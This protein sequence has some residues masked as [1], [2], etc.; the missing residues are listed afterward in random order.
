M[1]MV[2]RIF[3]ALLAL[4]GGR[5]IAQIDP[6]N[7]CL[8]GEWP[9]G[10]SD[11][12]A[13]DSARGLAFFRSGQRIIVA[14]VATPTSIEAISKTLEPADLAQD[15]FYD[16]STQRLYVAAGLAGLEI[17][18]LANPESPQ[19]LSDIQLDFF[20][21]DAPIHG[22]TVVGDWAYVAT[23]FRGVSWIDV[24]DPENPVAGLWISPCP[25]M[26]G[27]GCDQSPS[28]VF[29]GDDG[30]LYSTGR[31]NARLIIQPDGSLSELYVIGAGGVDIHVADGLA[32]VVHESLGLDIYDMEEDFPRFIY[33]DHKDTWTTG[34]V[35]QGDVGYASTIGADLLLY[36]VSDPDLIPNIGTVPVGSAHD[37]ARTGPTLLLI[38]SSGLTTLDITDPEAPMELDA[39]DVGG[40]NAGEVVGVGSFAFVAS[41]DVEVIDATEPEQPLPVNSFETNGFT[42]DLAL[43]GD[44]LF[45]NETTFND[46]QT[47]AVS[48]LDITDPQQPTML[49]SFTAVQQPAALVE[50][51]GLLY[52]AE[53]SFFPLTET[54]LRILDASDPENLTE[55]GYTVLG[56]EGGTVSVAVGNGYAYV[57][58]ITY[59]LD[60]PHRIRV[61][62][63]SEPAD[64]ATVGF[65]DLPNQSIAKEL[66]VANGRLHAAVLED[67]L[68][69]Y[70]LADPEQPAEIT[71]YSPTDYDARRVQVLGDFAYTVGGDARI[72]DLSEPTSP[73]TVALEPTSGSSAGLFVGQG[74][75][76]VGDGEHGVKV[77]GECGVTGDLD[78]DGDVDTQDLLML[79]A[80]WGDCPDPPEDCVADLDGN[81][82]VDVFD[83]LML[84]ADW[85]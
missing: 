55:V 73:V 36:D 77:F 69:I 21:E 7:F 50:K 33:K 63:V 27:G 40:F 71:I 59:D 2:T 49:D 1:R 43:A 83:L 28:D 85:G 65:V 70:D 15:L 61:V 13:V 18:D 35:R 26:G 66:S 30:Y 38:Q 81:G 25:T 9:F 5:A 46:P 72:I 20:G 78:G 39:L 31:N 10:P 54:A 24:G 42:T 17:W 67:G 82:A 76:L 60:L 53:S 68:V 4:T 62:N 23:T 29:L 12:I 37:I 56:D 45:L 6:E 41:G 32:F 64:P 16:D 22:V 44:V 75:M 11:Q 79:L 3:I 48:A 57:S 19:K 14:D 34:F 74:R 58:V 52:V 51:D 84:L 8:R 47:S 80:A